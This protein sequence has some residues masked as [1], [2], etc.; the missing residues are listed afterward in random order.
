M[1][2]SE[3]IEVVAK[4]AGLSKATVSKVINSY[5]KAVQVAMSQGDK[6]TLP[7]FGTFQV[8]ERKERSGRNPRTG[9]PMTIAAAKL[10][11]FKPGKLLKD[12]LA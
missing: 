6:V 11:R 1:N 10:P 9:D 12:S 4:E 3:L 2:K 7:G 5:H 8:S